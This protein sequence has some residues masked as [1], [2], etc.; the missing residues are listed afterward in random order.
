MTPAEVI[1][2]MPVRM[3]QLGAK[4]NASMDQNELTSWL[5]LPDII[6][7][8]VGEH[9]PKAAI[10]ALIQLM[11]SYSNNNQS[12]GSAAPFIVLFITKHY[13]NISKIQNKIKKIHPKF[14]HPTNQTVYIF[15]CS[16][17]VLVHMQTEF[18]QLQSQH[19]YN[20]VFRFVSI[21]VFKAF[22]HSTPSSLF[23]LLGTLYPIVLS[24]LPWNPKW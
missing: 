3:S 11:L 22:L 9:L 14:C 23:L 7:L 1:P 6:N 20:F 4:K 2:G 5:R 21:R 24:D 16:L 13:K 12:A 8:N 17:S 15:S 18:L 19:R 10:L